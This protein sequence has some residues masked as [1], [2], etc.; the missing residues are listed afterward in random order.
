MNWVEITKEHFENIKFDKERI[1]VQL[2]K[3]KNNKLI[4][5]GKCIARTQIIEGKVKY[6]LNLKP[7][8][9]PDVF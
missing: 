8:E 9:S 5:D 6:L 1:I 3:G 2:I 7:M 4:E